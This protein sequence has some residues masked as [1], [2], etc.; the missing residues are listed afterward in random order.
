MTAPPLS[1]SDAAILTHV[2]VLSSTAL[3]ATSA[4]QRDVS[5]AALYDVGATALRIRR[6]AAPAPPQRIVLQFPD[7]ALCDSVPV[8]WELKRALEEHGWEG[9][10][11][12]GADTS[13][14]K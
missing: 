2:P 5:L 4:Y 6:I 11:F 7:E 9:R 14:G 10:L 3:L 8:F 13:Y 1:T 12:I